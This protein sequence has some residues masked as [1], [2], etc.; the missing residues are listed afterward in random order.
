LGC[1]RKEKNGST[2]SQRK[3]AMSELPPRTFE[4]K[5]KTENTRYPKTEAFPAS[6]LKIY[7]K[8]PGNPLD[9]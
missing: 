8:I 7:K 9:T 6:P 1:S 4:E 2:T 5:V 3:T